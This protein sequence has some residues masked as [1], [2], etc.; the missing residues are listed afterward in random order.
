[1][2]RAWHTCK[3]L[4]EVG[5]FGE[6][7]FLITSLKLIGKFCPHPKFAQ[8]RRWRG[9]RI[10]FFS[11]CFA[12]KGGSRLGAQATKD[13]E[14]GLSSST[15]TAGGWGEDSASLPDRSIYFFD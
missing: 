9:K 11:S 7:S 1:M 15:E 8:R 10:L 6:N 14:G 5:I 2:L 13:T 4:V 3:T 12:Q